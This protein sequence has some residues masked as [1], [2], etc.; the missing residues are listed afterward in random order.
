MQGQSPSE[1]RLNALEAYILVALLFVFG[2][3][4]EFAFVLII[5]QN[6]IRSINEKK[7]NE[8]EN[9]F[10]A[11]MAENRVRCRTN[12]KSIRQVQDH[13]EFTREAEQRNDIQHLKNNSFYQ[14]MPLTT[15]IDYAAFIIFVMLY[16]TFNIIYFCIF[17]NK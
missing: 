13:V 3:I 4:I 17:L 9:E 11:Q 10:E 2:T 12:T 6:R 16:L 7:M 8:K 14:S 1:S 5:E 15:K